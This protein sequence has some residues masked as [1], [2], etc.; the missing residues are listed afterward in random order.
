MPNG[1]RLSGAR[2]RVRC[3]RGFGGISVRPVRKGLLGSVA[4]VVPHVMVG[5]ERLKSARVQL[6][7][8]NCEQ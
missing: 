3:S 2:M 5:N 6:C 7:D 4:R 1:L 8:L